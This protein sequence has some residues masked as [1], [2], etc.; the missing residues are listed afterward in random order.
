LNKKS[1]DGLPIV[2]IHLSGHSHEVYKKW[3]D[4]TLVI[5]NESEA[6]EVG[7]LEIKFIINKNKRIKILNNNDYSVNIEKYGKVDLVF[8]KK[9]EFYRRLIDKYYLSNLKFK[10]KSV[11]KK[12]DIPFV[13]REDFGSY[14]CSSIQKQLNKEIKL[15]HD[16]IH[17]YFTSIGNIRYIQQFYIH[18]STILFDHA[19]RASGI[20]QVSSYNTPYN[21]PG[22]PVYSFYLHKKM[23]KTLVTLTRLY[24]F[25]VPDSWMIFSDSLSFDWNYFAVP[26]YNMITNVKINGIPFEEF[27]E[28]VHVA[29]PKL[30]ALFLPKAYNLSF[31]L[32]DFIPKNRFGRDISNLNSLESNFKEYLLFSNYI[33]EN[34]NKK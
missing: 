21:L 29:A 14:F 2:D 31:G 28:Y 26:F 16:K 25:I 13:T 9:V 11:L 8:E 30:I 7:K 19:F 23:L 34:L 12:L 33:F 20:G 18:N 10:T 17:V 3:I 24:S 1:I 22:D 15:D 4:G 6:I 5:Q 27:P 32:I